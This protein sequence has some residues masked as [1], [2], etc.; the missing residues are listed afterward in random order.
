MNSTLCTFPGKFGDILW[1]LPTIREIARQ[2]GQP[3]HLAIGGK[4]SPLLEL[5][6]A[7]PYVA[8]AFAVEGW[9][10]GEHASWD[11][12]EELLIPGAYDKVYHLRY[13]DWPH[14][15]LPS[16]TV[17]TASKLGALYTPFGAEELASVMRSMD[18]PWITPPD[19]PC[20]SPGAYQPE[21]WPRA[22]RHI[23]LGWSDEHFELKLGLTALLATQ[24]GQ[25]RNLI[26][27]ALPRS[28]WEGEESR[29]VL[30]ADPQ[31]EY[32]EDL[33]DLGAG[34]WLM[35]ARTLARC[36]LYV[37]CLSAQWVLANALGIPCCVIEPN[38]ARH[39]PIFWWDGPIEKDGKPRNRMVL[40][41]DGK[42]TF[43]AR[44]AVLAVK[45]ELERVR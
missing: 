22:G 11:P 21:P 4:Y 30:C 1:A 32:G 29:R 24:L 15:S 34:D 44:A 20:S 8:A 25:Y 37:G 33:V 14:H 28:R 13:P 35:T 39:N 7:Q 10:E 36:K 31:S 2:A 18:Q 17:L 9:E 43:D 42:P 38:P 27:R 26:C 40:G 5:L 41:N 6:K 45:E 23:Y 12:P 19:F 16:E 3:V